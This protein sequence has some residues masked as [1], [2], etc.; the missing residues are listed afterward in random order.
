[1]D[2]LNVTCPTCGAR[3][4][5]AYYQ[6]HE[7]FHRALRNVLVALAKGNSNS[8]IDDVIGANL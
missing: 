4:D 8:A 1:M 5:N 7:E 3:V 6:Q 2:N